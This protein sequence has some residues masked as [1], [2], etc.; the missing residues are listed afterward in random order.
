MVAKYSD[1]VACIVAASPKSSRTS[2]NSISKHRAK[3]RQDQ[4]KGRVE[5]TRSRSDNGFSL[6][7]LVK[8][9]MKS[10]YDEREIRAER[11]VVICV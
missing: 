8:G 11:I 2:F 4:K 9:A 10:S 1:I 7:N 6:S 3:P 5:M